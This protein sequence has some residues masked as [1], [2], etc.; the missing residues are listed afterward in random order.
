MPYLLEKE[1][2]ILHS[3]AKLKMNNKLLTEAIYFNLPLQLPRLTDT[4]VKYKDVLVSNKGYFKRSKNGKKN[5]G[6]L[7]PNGYLYTTINKKKYHMAR[8]VY[9]AFNQEVNMIGLDV[10]HKFKVK[11]DNNLENL[12]LMNR[13]DNLEETFSQSK[14]RRLTFEMTT[15]KE[16]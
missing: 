7:T 14:K 16:N 9:G 11:T 2:N 6:W 13:R 3:K 5:Y 8:L 1:K 12:I 4:L 15:I 10:A